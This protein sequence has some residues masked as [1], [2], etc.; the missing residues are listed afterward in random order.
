M[1][2][3]FTKLCLKDYLRRKVCSVPNDAA[4]GHPI[5]DNVELAPLL[6]QEE[7][8]VWYFVCRR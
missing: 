3:L 6:S 1:S 8:L 2:T 4:D 7:E 5:P